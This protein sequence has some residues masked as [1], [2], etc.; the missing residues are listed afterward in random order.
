MKP[1]VL[2]TRELQ[3]RPLKLLQQHAEVIV[4]PHN[5]AMTP[6]EIMTEIPGKVG[7][8]AMGGDP[9]STRVLEP[10]P[11]IDPE[12]IASTSAFSSTTGPREALIKNEVF[13]IRLNCSAPMR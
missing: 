3:E 8:L 6:E 10:A 1:K 12:R 5:R 7:L 2:V 9:I 13:F 11:A 4:N